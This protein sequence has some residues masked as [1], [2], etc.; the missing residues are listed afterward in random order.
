MGRRR[1][2]SAEDALVALDDVLFGGSFV[3]STF[4]VDSGS[5]VRDIGPDFGALWLN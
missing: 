2:R 5:A 1:S 3:D 4:S